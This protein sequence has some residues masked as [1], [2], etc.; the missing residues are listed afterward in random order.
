MEDKSSNMDPKTLKNQKKQTDLF[1]S[2]S[3]STTRR[4]NPIL[5]TPSDGAANAM[6]V[7]LGVG[8]RVVVHHQGDLATDVGKKLGKEKRTPQNLECSCQDFEHYLG[9]WGR[10]EWPVVRNM[11][12]LEVIEQ[13]RTAAKKP[14][15]TAGTNQDVMNTSDIK[16]CV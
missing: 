8:R 16:P 13:P 15:G 3:K 12:L 10:A 4:R 9:L 7:V 6:N 11:Q 14:R 1:Q 5:E 2:K